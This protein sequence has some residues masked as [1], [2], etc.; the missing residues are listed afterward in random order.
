MTGTYSVRPE[1]K[2]GGTLYN[3][4]NSYILPNANRPYPIYCNMCKQELYNP[5]GM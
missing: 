2:P 1:L 4:Q 5:S 3:E